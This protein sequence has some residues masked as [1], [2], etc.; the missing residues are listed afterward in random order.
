MNRVSSY[1]ARRL[2]VL[3]F[4]LVVLGFAANLFWGRSDPVLGEA[5][6]PILMTWTSSAQ[7]PSL[8]EAAR[9]TEGIGAVATA[10][11]GVG[12]L[13]SWSAKDGK[14]GEAPAGFMVPIEV[15]A[16]VPE[17]YSAFVPD[18]HKTLFQG[19]AG[20]GALLGKSGASLRDI[21]SEGTLGFTRGN[22]PVAGVVPDELISS[23]EVVMSLDTAKTL[24]ISDLK[25]VLVELE[26]GTD[27]QEAEQ[28][29]R[30]KLPT[31]ARFGFRAPGDSMVFRPGGT[32][33]PQVEIKKKFGEFAG[34][35]GRGRAITI[36]PRWIQQNTTN[37]TFPL[38]GSARCHNKV[39]P[40]IRE[41]F[42][43]VVEQELSSLVRRRDFGGCF[44]PRFLNSDPNSGISHHS[45]GIAI[46]FNVSQNPYGVEPKMDMRLVELLESRGFTWGGRWVEPDGMH[47]E[48]LKEPDGS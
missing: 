22:I 45:W 32:I 12:W 48:Y 46:D 26:R 2:V 42:Q 5:D 29:L 17:D 14:A 11:N 28:A 24:G 40:Q 47:F 39:I 27:Q 8:A 7:L 4:V 41:A 30:S 1:R 19:L 21:D 38:L 6:A 10:R 23:H 44:S 37:V 36:D 25:Y 33:L 31:G 3:G 9:E 20:G 15:L 16:V 35:P 43:E 18:D 13:N 34:R